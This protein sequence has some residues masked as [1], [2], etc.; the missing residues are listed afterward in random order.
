MPLLLSGI[1]AVIIVMAASEQADA[2]P[3]CLTDTIDRAWL[4]YDNIYTGKV[5]AVTPQQSDPAQNGAGTTDRYPEHSVRIDFELEHVLKGYPPH[6]SWKHQAPPEIYCPGDF[7]VGGADYFTLGSVFFYVA[8]SDGYVSQ[9]NSCGLGKAE[10]NDGMYRTSSYDFFGY[11]EEIYGFLPPKNNPCSNPDHVLVLREN[12]RLACVRP[13]TAEKKI[14]DIFDMREYQANRP[15]G[16]EAV[17]EYSQS[18][19]RTTAIN[20]ET[21]SKVNVTL[22]NMPKIGETAEVVMVYT[23]LHEHG[24]TAPNELKKIL[25]SP[26]FEFVGIDEEK[27][28]TGVNRLGNVNYHAYSE[29]LMPLE[30]NQT[31]TMF[32]TV[33]AVS[34][35]YAWVTCGA[36]YGGG[37]YLTHYVTHPMIV[38]EDQTLSVKDYIRVSNP[39]PDMSMFRR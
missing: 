22:S 1:L 26:N 24:S 10:I 13:S 2:T 8:N 18:S 29:P 31:A 32:A 23:H 25:V 7:C 33:R 34:E 19:E 14:W 6:T 39:M 38:G 5:V 21:Y 20:W 35:G 9:Y 28:Y 3:P 11:F 15:N 16:Q 36:S 17:H 4:A 37:P 12:D 27:I 30:Q